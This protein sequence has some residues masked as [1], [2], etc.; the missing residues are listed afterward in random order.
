MVKSLI[1]LTVESIILIMRRGKGDKLEFET[2]PEKRLF[3]NYPHYPEGLTKAPAMTHETFKLIVYAMEEFITVKTNILLWQ[4]RNIPSELAIGTCEIDNFIE[5]FIENGGIVDKLGNTIYP[6]YFTLP[7]REC[8][9]SDVFGGTTTNFKYKLE[10]SKKFQ[11]EDFEDLY[12][13]KI[14]NVIESPRKHIT[15]DNLQLLNLYHCYCGVLLNLYSATIYYIEEDWDS[16]PDNLRNLVHILKLGIDPN[17]KNIDGSSPI[18]R[19]LFKE[20]NR[21]YREYADKILPQT[22]DI[23]L[24]YGLSKDTSEYSDNLIGYIFDDEEC[25]PLCNLLSVLAKHKVNLDKAGCGSGIVS[26]LWGTMA[27]IHPYFEG[28]IKWF[29]KH[30]ANIN[31]ATYRFGYTPLMA[32][33]LQGYNINDIEIMLKI[34]GIDLNKQNKYSRNVDDKTAL[35]LLF[36]QYNFNKGYQTKVLNKFIEFGADIDIEDRSGKT[37]R[38][39]A[40]EKSIP[41]NENIGKHVAKKQRLK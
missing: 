32:V 15:K 1:K 30:G 28:L 8:V 20:S 17:T 22:F 36:P 3:S 21:K 38:Q 7:I 13:K 27:Y 14:Q 18:K 4:C 40:E 16:T 37:V 39:L 2:T 6:E 19:F 31:S 25:P 41:I 29:M 34:E 35:H 10:Y 23:L 24:S 12:Q 11:N 33:V 9:I 26:M 5:C